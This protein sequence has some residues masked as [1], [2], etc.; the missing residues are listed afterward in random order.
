ML[1]LLLYT[2]LLLV[3][4][5][6]LLFGVGKMIYAYNDKLSLIGQGAPAVAVPA[7]SY[8]ALHERLNAAAKANP[9]LPR[10]KRTAS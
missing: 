5:P 9:I 7:P 1:E 4:M 6:A 3:L 8:E 2:G 10:W